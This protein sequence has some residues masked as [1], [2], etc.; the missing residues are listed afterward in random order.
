MHA[1]FATHRIYESE[2]KADCVE[3]EN[4]YKPWP[5]YTN[6]IDKT[7]VTW[8]STK[9]SREKYTNEI[10]TAIENNRTQRSRDDIFA[11][12]SSSSVTPV[13]DHT[14]QLPALELVKTLATKQQC[15][16]DE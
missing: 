1:K 15:R 4:I 9:R 8:L 13:I 2:Q 16:Y 6:I 11:T 7:T 10:K 14:S 12:V 3:E 5:R